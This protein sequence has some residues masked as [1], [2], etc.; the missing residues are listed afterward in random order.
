M[1]LALKYSAFALLATVLNLL[2]QE[3]VVQ[4]Y[5]GNHALY[6][7][8]AVGTLS[9]LISK[10]WLDK[11]YIFNV[12]F[13]TSHRDAQKFVV[14][15]LTGVVTT[16]IFWGFELAFD[17]LFSG[18]MARYVGACVGLAIGYGLKYRLDKHFV[19]AN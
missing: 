4:T 9:G 12:A 18:R 7:A 11:H 6:L 19:F 13:D 5:T 17:A 3:I 10:Y 8:M 14:Y 16:L 1:W 2:S 15:G